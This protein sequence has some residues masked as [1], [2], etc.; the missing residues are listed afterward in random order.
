MEGVQSKISTSLQ[1]VLRGTRQIPSK[2]G[3]EISSRNTTQPKKPE[4]MKESRG[5]DK[6]R[7]VELKCKF[8]NVNSLVRFCFS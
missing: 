2:K 6:R 7:P 3:P 4:K 1:A 5:E 8:H